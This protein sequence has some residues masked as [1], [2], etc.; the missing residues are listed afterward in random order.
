MTA[1]FSDYD[2]QKMGYGADE[3]GACIIRIGPFPEKGVKEERDD[4]YL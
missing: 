1:P 3:S 4:G 2:T